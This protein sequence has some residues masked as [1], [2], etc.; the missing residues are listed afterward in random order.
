MWSDNRRRIQVNYWAG[1]R[2]VA[3]K[4]EAGGGG[5]N[6]DADTLNSFVQDVNDTEN[7]IVL[8][9]NE[10]STLANSMILSLTPNTNTIVNGET[11]YNPTLMVFETKLPDGTL[12]QHG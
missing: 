10:G 9:D 8:R 7:T 4:I 1:I 5:W 6:I 11:Y 3:W 12:W 2:G